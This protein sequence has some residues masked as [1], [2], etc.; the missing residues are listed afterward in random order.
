MRKMFIFAVMAL[1]L[2]I[3][4]CSYSVYTNQYPYLKTLHITPFENKSTEYSLSQDIMTSLVEKYNQDNRLKLV[5]ISPDCQIEG[6]ILEYQKNIYSYD[7][8]KNIKEYQIK[9][10]LKVKFLDLKYNKVIWENSTLL[11]SE[12]YNVESGTSAPFKT[13]KEAQNSIYKEL[14]NQI[15]KYTLEEW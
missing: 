10:L 12:I 9:M 6:T 4:G 14:F 15:M 5:S 11:L 13:E 8:A 7:N 2:V 1:I 3:S